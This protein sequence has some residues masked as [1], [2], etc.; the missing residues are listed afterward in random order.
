MNGAARVLFPAVRWDPGR[1]DWDPEEPERLAGL[2]VGGF[3]VFGGA[4][5]A[6]AELTARLRSEARHPILIGADLERGAG[7]QF[8]GA[9]PLPPAAALAMLDDPAV[10]RRAAELTARE[11]V[12]LGIDWVYAPVADLDVE[13]DNPIVGTRSFG[14]D[15]DR[16]ARH[17][18]AWVEGCQTAGALA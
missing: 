18:A 12:A 7:Q 13:P 15:P 5:A 2:G 9:T 3:I 6:V 4:A 10:T 16:A 14:S 8:E 11:A 17:V 1:G